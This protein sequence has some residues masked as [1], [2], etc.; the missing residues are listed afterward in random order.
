MLAS[1]IYNIIESVDIAIVIN[2]TIKIITEQL[3]FPQTLIV[4]CTNLYLLYKCLVKLSITQ[5]KRL[6]INIIV[7]R[8]LY[9][10]R[11]ITEI[12]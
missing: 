1:E 6:I 11:K 10:Q 2:T 5:E 4:V 7:L 3:G 8:Q 12:Q 9:K